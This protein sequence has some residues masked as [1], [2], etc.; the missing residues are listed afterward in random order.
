MSEV[1]TRFAPSPTG[2]LHI[3]GART[4]L[5]NWLF[6]RHYGGKFILRIEDTD[7]RRSTPESVNAIIDGLGWL[8]LNWDEGPYYQSERTGIY[9][10]HIKRM[11]SAG[12]AYR[13][14]CTKEELD[15]KR[16]RALLEGRKPKYDGKCREISA[17]AVDRPY[18]IRFRSPDAGTTVVD[19]MI[20]GRVEFD[21]S[22]L[23][24]LIIARSDG[25]PTYN[26]VVVVDDAV[27]GITHLIRGDDH[28]NNTPRQILLYEAMG[29]E[30]PRFGHVPLILGPDRKRLSKRHG[31]TSL[32]AYRDMG[33]LPHSLV[34][35]LARLGWS[36]GDQEIF[37]LEELIKYFNDQ[38]IGKSAGVFNEDK[39]LWLNAHYI[40]ESSTEEL[41]ALLT[42][43]LEK[44][45]CEI[46]GSPPVSAI[47]PGLK[48]RSRTLVE[49]AEKAEF[50]FLKEIEIDE[51]AFE[52]FITPDNAPI[53]NDVISGIERVE[54]FK[55]ERLEEFFKG[56][57]EKSG[58]KLGKIAQPVRVAIT[59]GTVSPSIFEVIELLG[60]EV[61]IR[62][63]SA[64]LARI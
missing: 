27:M 44:K 43:F 62:R 40:K 60:R 59:G 49:M 39:L 48:D 11:T 12:R 53:L 24:D 25:S 41:T 51:K 31:A 45:G 4:A 23:D 34:N 26:F 14:Y 2:Y 8:G 19:D 33:F 5:F 7:T 22:E 58:L 55:A 47:I 46:A 30:R 1:R 28:L 54:P 38:S 18:V 63:I 37:S 3:G 32:T 57:A 13:C 35:Y 50:Y 10:E 20:K 17:K 56:L 36:H 42:L 6:A 61:I 16:S 52:K 29:Y 15:E 9:M 64:A 21:N